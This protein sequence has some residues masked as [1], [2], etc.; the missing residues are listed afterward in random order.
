MRRG[1]DLMDRHPWKSA[2]T[3]ADLEA[4][5]Y[6]VRI[7]VCSSKITPSCPTS[8]ARRSRRHATYRRLSLSDALALFRAARRAN[9]TMLRNLTESQW[10]AIPGIQEGVGT[11]SVCDVP[12]DDGRTR[13]R[14][15][16]EVKAWLTARSES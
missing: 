4:E 7:A 16:S 11:V 9:V 10:N 8:T 3:F 6:S 13:R 15:H 5:G 1:Q 2:G 12:D 14:H